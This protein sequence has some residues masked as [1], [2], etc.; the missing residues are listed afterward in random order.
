MLAGREQ[1]HCADFDVALDIGRN[2]DGHND[3]G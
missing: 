3:Y 1:L 2:H